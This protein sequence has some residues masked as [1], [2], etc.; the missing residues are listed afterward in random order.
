M[1]QA[2]SE[3]LQAYLTGQSQSTEDALRVVADDAV[4]DVGRGRYQGHDEIRAFL[5]RLRRINSRS[6]IVELDDVAPHEAAAVFEQRDDDLAPLGIESIRLNVRVRTTD[7]G[8][9]ESFTARPSPE[10]IQA[11][12]AARAAGR[13]SEGVR[14]AEQAGTL[15]DT[16][17]AVP[18]A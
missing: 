6:V 7:D 9:I 17:T 14:L 18:P 13:T 4:F 11:L 1:G 3:T 10:S 8:R 2:A 5:E 15:P 12:G 16:G